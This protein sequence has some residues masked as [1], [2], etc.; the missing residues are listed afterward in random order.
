MERTQ[1]TLAPRALGP[2]F[3]R[4]W[5]GLQPMLLVRD[6]GAWLVRTPRVGSR[7]LAGLSTHLLRDIGIARDQLD[8]VDEGRWPPP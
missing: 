5:A 2:P 8:L 6:F 3:G 1:R 7:S 4:P